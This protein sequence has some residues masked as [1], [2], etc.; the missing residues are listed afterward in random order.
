MVNNNNL[1]KMTVAASVLGWAV[2]VP[3]ERWPETFKTDFHVWKKAH[4]TV[5]KT[6]RCRP[7]STRTAPSG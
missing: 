3:V 7:A 4:L 5:A 2:P 6:A 1:E